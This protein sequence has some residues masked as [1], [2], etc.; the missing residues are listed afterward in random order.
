MNLSKFTGKQ[1]VKIMTVFMIDNPAKEKLYMQRIEG[2][3]GLTQR[4]RYYKLTT[5]GLQKYLPQ[6]QENLL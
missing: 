1:T 3:W 5:V 2:G 6:K 4:E